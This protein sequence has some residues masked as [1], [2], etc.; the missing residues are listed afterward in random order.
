MNIDQFAKMATAEA[1]A[2]EETESIITIKRY[3]KKR[4]A[5]IS[6]ALYFVTYFFA[7]VASIIFTMN[8]V[9]G[10]IAFI[11]LIIATQTIGREYYYY[12]DKMKD[13]VKVL[14]YQQ[15][16]IISEVFRTLPY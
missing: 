8:T 5:N 16:R 15:T 13:Y 11:I 2:E 6:F 10:I 9:Y 1:F 7:L 3:L 12:V 4:I 14:E